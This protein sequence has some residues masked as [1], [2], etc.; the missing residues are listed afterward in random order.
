[1]FK[2]IKVLIENL[3]E[4]K[5]LKIKISMLDVFSLAIK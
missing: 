3:H 2:I 1:M 4:I 5:K